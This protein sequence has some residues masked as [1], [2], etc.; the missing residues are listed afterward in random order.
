MRSFFTCKWSFAHPDMPEKLK[1]CL[2]TDEIQLLYVLNKS[3]KAPQQGE[4]IQKHYG[5]GKKYLRE[6]EKR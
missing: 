1:T 5:I 4:G 3:S 2:S 6:A